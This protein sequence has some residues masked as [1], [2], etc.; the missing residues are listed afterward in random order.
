M[1]KDFFIKQLDEIL[2]EFNAFKS[3]SRNNDLSDLPSQQV[4]MIIS[5]SKAAIERITGNKSE[6]YKI[7]KNY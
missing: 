3:S 6:Y 1:N 5:K 2:I 4:S 7:F